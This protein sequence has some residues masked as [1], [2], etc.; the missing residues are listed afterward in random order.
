MTED[1]PVTGVP[2]VWSGA[3]NHATSLYVFDESRALVLVP[4]WA[5][6]PDGT[7]PTIAIA[8]VDTATAAFTVIFMTVRSFQC[9]GFRLRATGTKDRATSKLTHPLR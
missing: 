1:A 3:W 6:T 8:S 9:K 5:R 4:P 2:P 7:M